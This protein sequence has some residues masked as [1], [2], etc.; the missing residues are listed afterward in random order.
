MVLSI[1]NLSKNLSKIK[2]LYDEKGAEIVLKK[3]AHFVTKI[4]RQPAEKKTLLKLDI[5]NQSLDKGRLTQDIERLLLLGLF[6]H[7]N[8]IKRDIRSLPSGVT[9]KI[10]NRAIKILNN[11]FEVYGG[12]S[13]KFNKEPFSW[14]C[15]PLSDFVWTSECPSINVLGKKPSG[16]DIKNVWEIAR[17]HFLSSLAY[18]YI[19]SGEE[20]FVSCAIE[21]VES[22]IDENQFLQGPHWTRA[23]EA[24]IRLINWCFYLPLLD[25]FKLSDSSFIHKLVNSFLEHLFYIKENLEISPSHTGNHYL[26]DL[27]GLLMGRLIFPS[28]QW[29]I[30]NAEFAEK[31]LEAEVEKQFKES[32]I[33][34]EGS[35]SYHRLS[36]EICLIGVA[37]IKKSCRYVSPAILQRL[38][39]T[40]SFTKFY[41]DLCDN[42]PIIGDNDSGVFVKFFDG[43]ELNRH[44]Y[45][46]FLFDCILEDKYDPL[47]WE[48]F[49]S[50]IHFVKPSLPS[51]PVRK[52]PKD[53]SNT[54]IEVKEFNGLIIARHKNEGLFF[55]A[56]CASGGHTHNDKL[57]VFP[58]I[59]N[60]SL[61][62]DRGS[63]SYTGFIEKRHED[64]SSASH[65][66]PVI[67][68]WEQNAIWKD[69]VFF[70]G[71]DTR[72]GNLVE[73]LGD[74]ISITGWHVGYRRYGSDIKIF[75]RVVWKIKKRTMRI[76]DWIEATKEHQVFHFSWRFLINPDLVS[77]L[78]DK[79]LVLGG[80]GQKIYFENMDGLTFVL[81]ES[82]YCPTYQVEAPCPMLTGSCMSRAGEKINFQLSY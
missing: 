76:T 55:N 62:L 63:F 70:I 1:D 50:A 64:R 20:R 13:L 75:R 67:N 74:V 53:C 30:Q 71:G 11:E 12:L 65:N 14:R 4:F 2:K 10:M 66:G 3:V 80:L 82:V 43:Q 26:A 23:M 29:A 73:S 42:C 45:L 18:A 60:R 5:L 54:Q 32:G 33:N 49:L 44:Q 40:A 8:E 36:S 7:S 28:T 34:F 9:I 24:S 48:E 79:T 52:N 68:G 46:K 35:L 22:W 27:V 58:I 78:D 39:Q 17:F 59:E 15:D 21:K 69:D 72:C 6:R 61:F 16:I 37:I 31:E 47:T 81:G 25:I 19:L 77:F 41:C 51:C 38:R 57:S 56:L